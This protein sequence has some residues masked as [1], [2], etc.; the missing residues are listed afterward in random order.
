[1]PQGRSL[2][3]HEDLQPQ[4]AAPA[5]LDPRAL[6]TKTKFKAALG[7]G[8][9]LTADRMIVLLTYR[10]CLFN[11]LIH[12]RNTVSDMRNATANVLPI[13]AALYLMRVTG[14]ETIKTYVNSHK[15]SHWS[16]L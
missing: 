1:M 6:P 8:T 10:V 7:L 11:Q 2:A 12:F 4:I 3:E 16:H 9:R 15:S 14:L 5:S 13:L